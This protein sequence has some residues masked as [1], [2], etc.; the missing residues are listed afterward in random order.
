MTISV[1][2]YKHSYNIYMA[3]YILYHV[4]A[5][6]IIRI[7]IIA[8]PNKYVSKKDNTQHQQA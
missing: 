7:K 5:L 6:Q 4:Y 8:I 2:Q 1:V 3:I